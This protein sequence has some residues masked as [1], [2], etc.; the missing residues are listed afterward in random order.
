MKQSIHLVEIY[1]ILRGPSVCIHL[2]CNTKNQYFH[3]FLHPQPQV[4]GYLMTTMCQLVPN[5]MNVMDNVM[6]PDM[7]QVVTTSMETMAMTHVM[8]CVFDPVMNWRHD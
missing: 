2:R 6:T 4:I 3:V 1:A 7:M 5:M 8:T